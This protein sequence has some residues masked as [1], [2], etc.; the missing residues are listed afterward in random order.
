MNLE[1]ITEEIKLIKTRNK[2]VELDKKWELSITRKITICIF[3]Y[4][5]IVL[6]TLFINKKGNVFL[7]S[8]VPVIGFFL[9]TQSLVLIKKM[10][11]NKNK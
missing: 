10:W 11:L 3:T 2:K 1:E 7:N 4:I 5:V 6:F 9:S 8:V